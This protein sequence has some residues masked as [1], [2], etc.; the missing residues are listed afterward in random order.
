MLRKKLLLRL[1]FRV[2]VVL[3]LKEGSG[4]AVSPELP[5]AFISMVYVPGRMLK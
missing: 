1:F 5:S 3:I 2:N 4:E